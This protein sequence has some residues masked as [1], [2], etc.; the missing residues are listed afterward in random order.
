M[1]VGGQRYTPAALLPGKTWYPLHRWAPGPVWRCAEN[2]APTGIQS[3]ERPP[4]SELLFRLS[5]PGPLICVIY[6][7]IYIYICNDDK[8][9]HT[10]V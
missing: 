3:P 8:A 9:V 6:I 5:S 4:R 2:L 7:Y 10:S 1:G